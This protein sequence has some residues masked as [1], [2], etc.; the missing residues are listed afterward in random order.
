MSH[1]KKTLFL[2]LACL[3]YATSMTIPLLAQGEVTLSGSTWTATVNGSTVYTGSRMFEAAN[4][5][6]NSAGTG[7]TINIRNSGNSGDDNGGSSVYAIRPLASQTLNFH[8]N[9]VNCNS[10]GELAV[11]VYA[12]R[13]DNVTVTNLVVTGD[14]RYGVWFRG[15]SNLTLTNITMNLSHPAQVGLGIRVDASSGP[16]SN[17]T[18]NGDININGS[19]G[20]AIETYSISGVTIGDVNVHNSGGCGVLLNDS[21]NCTVGVVTGSYNCYGGGYATFRTANNNRSTYVEAVYSANSGR[22]FFSVSGSQ[23]CTIGYVE[24]TAAT[25]IGIWIQDSYNTHVNSGYVWNTDCYAITNGSGNSV[26]VSCAAPSGGGSYVKFQNRNTGL[27]MDG[28]GRVYDGEDCGQWSSSVS[29]NQQWEVINAGSYVR[30]KNRATGLY[31]DGM[32]RTSNGSAAGQWTGSPNYNQQWALE[33]VSG[34]VKFRNR[35]TSLYLDGLG[36]TSNGANLAQWASSTHYNQQWS[37]VSVSSA[38]LAETANAEGIVLAPNPVAA[39]QYFDVNLQSFANDVDL[40]VVDLSGKVMYT[41]QYHNTSYL[42]VN[43]SL[44]G[45]A[46]IVRVVAD[47]I[48]SSHKLVIK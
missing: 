6:C 30:L 45:G 40:Q 34:Y 14:P 1:L 33:T 46:Y 25:D 38:S 24:I 12:D 44:Q 36:S 26:S 32:G 8:G 11:A 22:G 21:E 48:G 13:K 7:A 10:S 20:H 2:L 17:L 37:S 35:T 28:L 3:A 18:I 31:L 29:F 39:Q 47:G 4:A 41:N 43:P 23:D 19:L 16:A 42:S 27:Y 5:A 15:C 9:T